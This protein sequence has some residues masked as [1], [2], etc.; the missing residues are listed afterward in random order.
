LHFF[1]PEEI[2]PGAS[3]NLLSL[4]GESKFLV[5]FSYCIGLLLL[6]ELLYNQLQL[7]KY[8][9]AKTGASSE[10]VRRR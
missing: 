10:P 7:G 5:L 1:S 2:L 8:A 9:G 3:A 4:F 6:A